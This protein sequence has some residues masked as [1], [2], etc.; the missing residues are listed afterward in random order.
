MKSAI[1]A[2]NKIPSIPKNTGK[3]RISGIKQIISRIID[4]MTACIGLP[5]A[6]KKIEV[7]FMVQVKVTS[8]RKMRKVFS[9][10]IQ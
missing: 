7:I 2:A 9:A 1:G 10:K 4:E 3:M 8:E 6:W 5:T